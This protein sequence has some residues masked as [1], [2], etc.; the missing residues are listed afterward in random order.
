ML[1]TRSI[2]LYILFFEGMARGMARQRAIP[3]SLQRDATLWWDDEDET[4]FAL[5]TRALYPAAFSRRR[6]F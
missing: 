5:V 2:L 1:R 3:S 4:K 6:L